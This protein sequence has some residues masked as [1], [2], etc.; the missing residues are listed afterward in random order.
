[1]WGHTADGGC[2]PRR[3]EMGKCGIHRIY[4]AGGVSMESEYRKRWARRR[5]V[6]RKS[7]RCTGNYRQPGL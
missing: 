2:T 4:A 3:I 5:W 7:K 6:D 1:M